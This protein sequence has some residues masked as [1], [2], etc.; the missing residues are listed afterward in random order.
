MTGPRID[1][2]QPWH[3][4]KS[5]EEWQAINRKATQDFHAS[6]H[7]N[8]SNPDREAL[9]AIKDS[10]DAL[11]EYD[12][13]AITAG[14]HTLSSGWG[15][16]I[17]GLK[18]EAEGALGAATAPFH[19]AN[20][21]YRQGPGA[22]VDEIVKGITSIPGEIASGDPER[23]GS[24]AGNVAGSIAMGK[25]GSK[26]AKGAGAVIADYAERPRL[27][28]TLLKTQVS[29]L[30][31]GL[32]KSSAIAP[33]AIEQAGLKTDAMKQNINQKAELHPNRM[34]QSGLKTDQ[35]EQGLEK[36]AQDIKRNAG[37]LDATTQRPGLLNDLTRLQI[38]KLQ[39]LIDGMDDESDPGASPETAPLN[40]KSPTSGPNPQPELPRDIINDPKNTDP[41]GLDNL[42]KPT[43]PTDQLGGWINDL[44]RIETRGKAPHDILSDSDRNP[45]VKPLTPEDINELLN[46]INKKKGPNNP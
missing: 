17:E 43:E 5:P 37:S 36:G 41:Y 34:E 19:L 23:I 4:Q 18:G 29:A 15:D 10:N 8:P 20:T 26:I 30:Q 46:Q 32:A 24:V 35:M 38:E 16:P 25:L 3:M 22:G 21:I 39:R 14:E 6:M 28:N 1:P 12:K 27:K 2:N 9:Q 42:T 7:N 45:G 31:H 40:P 44:K 33:D 13:P 11:N